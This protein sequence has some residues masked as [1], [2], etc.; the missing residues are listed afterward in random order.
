M[1][2]WDE[3]IEDILL[4]LL[5]KKYICS[6]SCFEGDWQDKFS[7]I[8]KCLA[9]KAMVKYMSG[10]SY[11]PDDSYS[12]KLSRG[13]IFVLNFRDLNFCVLPSRLILDHAPYSLRIRR[14]ALHCLVSL[15]YGRRT[16]WTWQS[17]RWSRKDAFCC[18]ES[19]V[20]SYRRNMLL[21]TCKDFSEFKSSRFLF[22]RLHQGRENFPLY[23]I[24][25]DLAFPC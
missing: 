3:L 22:S 5:S 19:T 9:L 13:Q 16:N 20:K 25:T 14:N 4:L 12:R 1:S 15:L 7:G 8:H 2:C 10:V 18:R 21:H 6:A 23:G 11:W 17:F 24:Q